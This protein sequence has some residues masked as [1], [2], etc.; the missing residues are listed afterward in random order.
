MSPLSSLIKNQTLVFLPPTASITE[1]AKKMAD[2]LI[3]SVLVME[4]DKL[5]GIFTER[6]L[7]NRVVAKNLDPKSTKLSEVM[8]KNV[9]TIPVQKTVEDCFQ[10]MEET[11]CRHIPIVD[12]NKVVGVVTMRNILEWLTEE[13]KEE[14]VFLRNYIQS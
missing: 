1:A 3:G 13:M 10:K 14:N 9:C 5:V 6:D 11:K 8:S 4:G 7:L 2:R 12:G